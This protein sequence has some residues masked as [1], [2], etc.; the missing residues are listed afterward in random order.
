M[1]PNARSGFIVGVF[2]TVLGGALMGTAVIASGVVDIAATAPA[3]LPDRVLAFASTQAIRHHARAEQNPLAQ[4][5]AALQRGLEAYRASCV[6]CH[7]GPGVEPQP[8]SAGLHPSAPD[9]TTADVQAFTDGMLYETIARGIGSTGM[10]AFGPGRT[11]EEL[12]SLVAAVRHLSTLTAAERTVLAGVAET[13]PAAAAAV[14]TDAG[15][16]SAASEAKVHR[17][18]ISNFKF[19]PAQL[20]ANVGDVVEWVNTDFAA[21][22]AT[23]DDKSFDTGKIDSSQVKR[24]T[25]TRPGSHPYFCRYHLSMRGTVEVK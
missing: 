2:A 11:P 23:A 7:A 21:H 10:P 19:E 25:L 9:L 24:V 18:S 17:V 8:F 14:P 20:Q 22:T 4:D 1:E 5:P 15:P 12:W 6:A 3:G 16:S 13:R